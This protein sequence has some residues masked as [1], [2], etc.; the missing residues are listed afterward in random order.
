M[1][2]QTSTAAS[3]ARQ[4]G[5]GSHLDY[6]S[7]NNERNERAS[8]DVARQPRQ[9]AQRYTQA[10]LTPPVDV[11]EDS[12]G[13]TLYADLPGVPKDKLKLQVEADTLTIEAEAALNLPEGL[14]SSHTEVGLARFHRVFTLSKELDTENVS[15]ELTQGVLKL[16]IPKAAH[17]Q[18]R[19]ISISAG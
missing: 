17:A 12:S 14:Q 7:L 3:T 18:P 1:N 8:G 2:T 6:S 13:I 10:T 11:I 15:A 4:G 19:R 16:R 5:N 9:Q